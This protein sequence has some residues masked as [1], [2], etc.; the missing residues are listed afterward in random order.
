MTL[1][2]YT[3][4]PKFLK[5]PVAT[6]RGWVDSS[7]GEIVVAIPNLNSFGGVSGSSIPVEN[8]TGLVV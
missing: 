4:P 2:S 1:W 5:N 3:T 6:K 7:T 8:T